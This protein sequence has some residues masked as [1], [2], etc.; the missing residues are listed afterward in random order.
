MTDWKSLRPIE[1]VLAGPVVIIGAVAVWY[2]VGQ[3][4]DIA[5]NPDNWHIARLWVFSWFGR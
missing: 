2:V 1:R 5:L 3:F 4:N